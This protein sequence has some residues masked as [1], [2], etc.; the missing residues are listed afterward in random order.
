VNSGV[1]G[2]SVV[3]SGQFFVLK[4]KSFQ[5]LVRNVVKNCKIRGKLVTVD[6]LDEFVSRCMVKDHQ[7]KREIFFSQF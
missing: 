3:P 2:A 1:R 4:K 6:D 5:I 7:N